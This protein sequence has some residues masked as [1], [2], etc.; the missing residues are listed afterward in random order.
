M[1]DD[2]SQ[3]PERLTGGCS[4]GAV[5]YAIAEKPLAGARVVCCI[6]VI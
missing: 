2:V 6:P 3:A 1:S 4:C 5:R